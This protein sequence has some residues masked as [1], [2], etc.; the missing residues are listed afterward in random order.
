MCREGE[1]PG[2]PAAGMEEQV[3]GQLLAVNYA[4]CLHKTLVCHHLL[5]CSLVT[6]GA[7]WWR[8]HREERCPVLDLRDLPPGRCLPARAAA[9]HLGVPGLLQ[10]LPRIMYLE[11][12]TYS[13]WSFY[14]TLSTWP[15]SGST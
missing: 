15:T 3:G 10:V 5:I 4:V 14:N 7:G 8:L 1:G 11:Y 2:T 9:H 13:S 6:V 12:S